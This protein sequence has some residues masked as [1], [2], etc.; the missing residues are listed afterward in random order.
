MGTLISSTFCR[1][2]C[3]TSILS[4]IR[5][6]A[7]YFFSYCNAADQLIYLLLTL[8]LRFGLFNVHLWGGVG[9]AAPLHVLRKWKNNNV[10]SLV[11]SLVIF[12]IFEVSIQSNRFEWNRIR[13]V[14]FFTGALAADLDAV[15]DAGVAFLAGA[16]L[17]SDLSP[18]LNSFSRIEAGIIDP[19]QLNLGMALTCV[20][21]MW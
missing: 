21:I 18:P 12:E 8:A 4:F 5:Y 6:N 15:L 17:D 10:V 13:E 2:I 1:L 11:A 3:F 7:V 19:G 9:T 14:T 20:W 16:A